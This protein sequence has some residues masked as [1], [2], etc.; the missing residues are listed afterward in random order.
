VK[1]SLGPL[2]LAVILT[3]E[4]GVA[5][6]VGLFLIC[7]LVALVLVA[8]RV[9]QLEQTTLRQSMRLDALEQQIHPKLHGT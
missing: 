7:A 3:L 2:T 6:L 9:N 4:N 5:A 1:L 8:L